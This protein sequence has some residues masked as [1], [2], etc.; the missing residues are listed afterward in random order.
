[1][2]KQ[3]TSASDDT[4]CWDDVAERAKRARSGGVWVEKHSN[5]N[6]SDLDINNAPRKKQIPDATQRGE[7]S[8]QVPPTMNY[9]PCPICK[10]TS[11]T[12]ASCPQ[13]F[14]ERCSKMGHLAS[15][16]VAFLPWECGTDVCFSGQGPGFLLH[17]RFVHC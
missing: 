3:A 11:H 14:C 6:P 17:P 12:P 8:T 1:M 15:V 4:T 7:S 2:N 16:C 13:A 5:P 9:D 10:A